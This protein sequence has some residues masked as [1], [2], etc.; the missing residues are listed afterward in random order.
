MKQDL[1]NSSNFGRTRQLNT[2]H[3]RIYIDTPNCVYQ[4]E[5]VCGSKYIGRTE[6]QLSTRMMEHLPKWLETAECKV[7]KSS[8]T[9]HL[10][11]YGHDID[12]VKSLTSVS[13]QRNKKILVIRVYKPG[14]CVQKE[15]VVTLNLP[16]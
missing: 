2:L 5:C 1:V 4:F 7:S 8:V 10:V 3:P 6:R 12:D 9:K 13:K 11:D 15:M 14:L 16:W